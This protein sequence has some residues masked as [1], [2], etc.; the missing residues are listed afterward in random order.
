MRV[1][2][3]PLRGTLVFCNATGFRLFLVRVLVLSDFGGIFGTGKCGGGSRMTLGCVEGG[4]TGFE[5]ERESSETGEGDPRE[6]V[7]DW[8]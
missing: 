3:L 5:G 2:I 6:W 1:F 7:G 4:E 8:E